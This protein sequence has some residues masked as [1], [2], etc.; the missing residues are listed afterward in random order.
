MVKLEKHDP[1][2]LARQLPTHTV[3]LI[4][5]GGRGTRLKDLTAKRAK[6][7]V[8]FGG[9]YRI[10]DFALSNCLNSGI[11]RIAVCTQYQSHTL[12]QHI[13]RGW[14]F[15]NE[16]MN[17]FVD[18]LPAQQRLATDHWYR[19]TADAVTQNLDIIR[20]Y[21]AK[22]IVILAGD[23]IYK[24]DYARML[25]DH[26]EHGARC[27][28]A[29]LPVP[30]EE[31]SAF[32]V[33]KVDDDNRVVEFLEKPDNPPSMP[34]DASRAL[35]SM[36]VYVFDAEYLFDLLEHDQQLPQ[37]THDFGQDLLPKIVA[38]GEALAHSFSLSCVHQDETAEPYWRDVGTLEAYWKANLD[39]A[40]VTPELDMYDADWPIHTHMEPLPP[41]KFVQ[42]RSGSHGMTMNSLVSGGC[43]ISGSVVVNSVLFSR[44]RINSFCN[45]ESSVLLPDVVVGRSCRLR[46]CVIDRACVLPEGTVIGENP[47]DD[48]RRFHR[49]EEGIVLVTTTMLAKLGWR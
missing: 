35:A 33:M 23:H 10:I 4:L 7:A 41:A 47:D 45:I 26:V 31:A 24:M 39:L 49:S 5:A 1:V 32:G 37:S 42:D 18:L 34:G 16:E 13:Q 38:S 19:G 28:I 2:M 21:R 44:V 48:A 40:S 29:C 11:R 30:L 15:L 36:G 46:R 20:R 17:E 6:P 43:I 3:A 12:V 27:T 9:K 14:S 25:I 22:Y 8:H